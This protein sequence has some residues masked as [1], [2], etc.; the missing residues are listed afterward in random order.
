LG[1]AASKI[2]DKEQP[3]GRHESGTYVKFTEAGAALFSNP[4]FGDMAISGRQVEIQ[5]EGQEP[6]A[7]GDEPGD[8]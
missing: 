7:S 4:V 5:A 1:S 2:N 3:L 6:Q 8:G